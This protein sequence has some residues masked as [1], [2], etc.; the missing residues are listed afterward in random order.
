MRSRFSTPLRFRERVE[1]F[2]YLIILHQA[3]NT[4]QTKYLFQNYDNQDFLSLLFVDK[5]ILRYIYKREVDVGWFYGK[6]EQV[7]FTYFLE[8]YKV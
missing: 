5:S 4:I 8:E 1:G 3:L 6:D 7:E 2:N